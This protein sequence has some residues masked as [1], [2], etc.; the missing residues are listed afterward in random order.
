MN[1]K[2]EYRKKTE[3]M[4]YQN[5]TLAPTTSPLATKERDPLPTTPDAL[6]NSDLGV[7]LDAHAEVKLQGRGGDLQGS[8]DITLGESVQQVVGRDRVLHHTEIGGAL[9]QVLALTTG[10]LGTDLL[11]IDALDRQALCFG[12]C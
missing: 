1:E 3:I 8:C 5:D 2:L 12:S 9:E 7:H 6:A 10:I 11:A 4:T